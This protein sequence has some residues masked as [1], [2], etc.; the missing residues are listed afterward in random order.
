MLTLYII[1]LPHPFWCSHQTHTQA[2]LSLKAMD[3]QACLLDTDAGNLC[4]FHARTYTHAEQ[5]NMSAQLKHKTDSPSL[6][7]YFTNENACWHMSINRHTHTYSHTHTTSTNSFQG[8][9]IQATLLLHGCIQSRFSQCGQLTWF[10]NRIFESRRTHG[11][12]ITLK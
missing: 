10:P 7:Q 1:H 6:F 11:I 4:V 5:H 2:D 9:S 12:L 3:Q 8:F